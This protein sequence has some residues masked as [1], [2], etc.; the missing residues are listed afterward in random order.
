[1]LVS[2]ENVQLKLKIFNSPK[3]M[4][5]YRLFVVMPRGLSF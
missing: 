5:E 4:I 2:M 3:A 1:M